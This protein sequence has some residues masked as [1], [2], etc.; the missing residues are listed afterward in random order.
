MGLMF[1]VLMQAFAGSRKAQGLAVAS[2]MLKHEGQKAMHRVHLELGQ[3]RKLLASNVGALAG[4]NVGRDYFDAI[5]TLGG[6]IPPVSA[7]DRAFPLIEQNSNFNK[8]G[9]DEGEMPYS[10]F[11]NALIFVKREVELPI[12]GVTIKFGSGL[13][14]RELTAQKPFRLYVYRFIAYYLGEVDLPENTAPL[15]GKNKALVLCRFESKPYLEKNEAWGFMK[16]LP[17]AA[18][19]KLVW[20][21]KLNA[22]P[23]GE[24]IVGAWDSNANNPN[25]AFYRYDL[26]EDDMLAVPG[27]VRGKQ[28]RPLTN[29]QMEPYAVGTVSYNAGSNYPNFKVAGSKDGSPSFVVPAFALD[30]ELASPTQV[31]YGFEVGIRGSSAGRSVL[32]RLALAARISAGNHLYGHIH[33]EIVQVFDN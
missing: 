11:G 6:S 21:T 18:D 4:E 1:G 17:T 2:Q 24:A 32:M 20:D 8:M 30:P 9:N 28:S 33:Q 3:A 12:S 26:P 7:A 14:D 16:M 13:V 31:P 22:T 5:D 23:D 19:R 15:N 10:A 29:F 27:F 25:V